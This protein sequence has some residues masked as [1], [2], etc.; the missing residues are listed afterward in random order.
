MRIP[1]PPRELSGERLA[2]EVPDNHNRSGSIYADEFLTDYCPPDFDDLQRRQFFCI[3]DLRRLKYAAN[4][5]FAKKDWKLNILNFAK[6]YEKSRSL[7]MLRYGLYEFK[8]VKASEAVKKQWKKDHG[9]PDSDDEKEPEYRPK[10]NGTQGIL[11]RPGG[12]RKA[13]DDIAP[14]EAARP[15]PAANLN[16]R[17]ATEREPL[18]ETTTPVSNKIKRKAEDA[19]GSPDENQPNKLQKSVPS[20]HK[21]SSLAVKSIFEKI[22]NGVSV[23]D[24][25][26]TTSPAKPARKIAEPSGALFGGAKA[27]NGSLGRSVLDPA[28]KPATTNNIFG[29][30]SD[31]SKGSGNDDADAESGDG[32]DSD[33]EDAE[34]SDVQEVKQSNGFAPS[35]TGAAPKFGA[36]TGASVFFKQGLDNTPSSA[37]SDAGDGGKARSL[38]DRVTYGN[39]GQP[40][41]MFQ[42]QA[43][44][45][46]EATPVEAERPASPAK[47]PTN[48]TWNT[49]TPIKFAPSAPQSGSILGTSTPQPTSLFA[50]KE[51]ASTTPAPIFGLTGPKASTDST[52]TTTSA[53]SSGFPAF[54]G[55]TSAVKPTTSNLFGQPKPV[56]ET[57]PATAPVTTTPAAALFGLQPK[58]A[59][60]EAPKPAA[61]VFQ[62]STLFGNQTKPADANP[63]DSTPKPLFGN[64]PVKPSASLGQPN[65]ATSIFGNSAAKPAASLFGSTPASSDASTTA[66]T[67]P[68][69]G[70]ASGQPA[71][72]LFGA[73]ATAAAPES[74]PVFGAGPTAAGPGSSTPGGIFGAAGGFGQNSTAPTNN[75]SE[76][77]AGKSQSSLFS[78]ASSTAPAAGGLF[79]FGGTS[80][81]STPATSF[82][83]GPSQANA[84]QTSAPIFGGAGGG[85]G[86]GGS[87]FTFTAGG[88]NKAPF[89][90]PFAANGTGSSTPSFNFGGAAASDASKAGSPAPFVFGGGGAAPTISFGSGS[91]ASTPTAQ[92]GNLF[93]GASGGGTATP[94]FSFGSNGSQP[95]GQSMFSQQKAAPSLFSGGLAPLPGGTSSGTSKSGR[96][97]LPGK[98]QRY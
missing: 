84:T 24:S 36:A 58:P 2:K 15:T 3:L 86:G 72:S 67:K 76:D 38:F 65:Q 68:L 21:A 7:I 1:S 80:Q 63:V 81:T 44:K 64:A 42:P 66:P 12:K 77:Q 73:N 53:P 50:P 91:G 39:D 49:G 11:S 60:V 43:E 31:A 88:D 93:G 35:A 75:A 85:G 25:D 69:F 37:S 55:A 23:D 16:K 14:K 70:A 19:L 54:G 9:I 56:E 47:A 92:P 97:I 34:E 26:T 8:T 32:T 78:N 45:S 10:P 89:N 83:Q 57:K 20:P 95:S 61:S 48:N 74:K 17:R 28:S 4:E 33:E 22:A 27:V 29:H 90:N 46:K 96:R 82:G 18:A 79:S 13:E 62:S 6:E 40:V 94:T 71:P 52:T 41:R 51:P 98:R 5:I 87:S 59:E 30:L